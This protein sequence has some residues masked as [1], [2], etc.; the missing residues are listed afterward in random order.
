MTWTLIK[1]KK[2]K[3]PVKVRVWY[4]EFGTWNYREKTCLRFHSVECR[5]YFRYPR[6]T[7]V[8]WFWITNSKWVTINPPLPKLTTMQD[9]IFDLWYI[10]ISKQNKGKYIQCKNSSFGILSLVYLCGLVHGESWHLL[11]QVSSENDFLLFRK[12]CWQLY[13]P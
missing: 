13:N 10:F 4:I 5:V 2:K 1:T 7:K 6:Q 3:R 8:C 11:L 12:H 9:S